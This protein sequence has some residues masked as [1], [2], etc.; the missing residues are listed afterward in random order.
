MFIVFFVMGKSRVTP[1]KKVTIP[2]LELTA[3]TVAVRTDKLIKSEL[4]I[5]IHISKFWT[6]SLTVIKYIRNFTSRFNTF[7][8]SRLSVIHEATQIQQWRYVSTDENPTDDA[9]R[10][11]TSTKLKGNS[12]WLN[13]PE[14][15]W[16]SEIE[17]PSIPLDCDNLNIMNENDPE[18]NSTKKTMLP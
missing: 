12:R 2:R 15:L 4:E 14:F 6:D 11:L 10:S 1:L 16:K 18:V 13:G 8:A 9:S 17:W 5:P 3:A 7:V